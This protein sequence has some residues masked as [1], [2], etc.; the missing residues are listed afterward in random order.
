ML[1]ANLVLKTPPYT[2]TDMCATGMH[3]S[4]ADGR[5]EKH[6]KNDLVLSP[7]PPYIRNTVAVNQSNP[8]YAQPF[9]KL[10]ENGN[11]T[12]LIQCLLVKVVLKN[13]LSQVIFFLYISEI[14][15]QFSLT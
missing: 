7:S 3:K 1:L 5:L 12:M 10:N 8:G 14:R 4:Q 11:I 9:V 13:S 2:H 6:C 15:K